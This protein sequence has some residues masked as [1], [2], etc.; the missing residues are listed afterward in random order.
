MFYEWLLGKQIPKA[1][2]KTFKLS[3]FFVLS[4][5]ASVK[6]AHRMLMK[7]TPNR[8]QYKLGLLKVNTNTENQTENKLKF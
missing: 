4:G 3:V 2:K 5:S 7:L 1:Q 6:A 8:Y